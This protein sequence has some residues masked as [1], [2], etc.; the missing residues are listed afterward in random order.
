[1]QAVEG[2]DGVAQQQWEALNRS[3]SRSLARSLSLSLSRACSLSLALALSLSLSFPPFARVVTE[4]SATARDVRDP[5]GLFPYSFPL[6]PYFLFIPTSLR[7]LL[8]HIFLPRVTV[9]T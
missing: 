5:R 1:M 2:G 9:R 3:L 8:L 4:S 6:P 7:F